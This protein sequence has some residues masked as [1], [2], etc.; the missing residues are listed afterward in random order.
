MNLDAASEYILHRLRGELNASLTYHCVEHTLDVLEA[1]R[2]LADSENIGEHS[3]AILETAALYHDAGMIMQY[4]DH[5]TASALLAR[6]M[7]P[8]FGYTPAEV[9]AVTGL[10]MVT[11]LPQRP[12]NHLE[13]IL[14]D[15][16]LDYL[17][18]EDFYVH[19][20][21][22]QLEWRMNNV[23]TTTL[24][25]WLGIQ[26]SFLSEHRYF[27]HSAIAQRNETK[28]RHLGEIRDLWQ[29]IRTNAGQPS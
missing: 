1:T 20:F 12:Y 22:L 2:R 14:C 11:K 27:T 29:K 26:V 10:I 17:G 7:L 5:E 6:E 18:R 16:D 15:A 3:R 28:L 8:G 23:K 4:R 19:S 21:S 24:A 13:Q 25:E 9:E